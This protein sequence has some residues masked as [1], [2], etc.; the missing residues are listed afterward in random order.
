MLLE[1][2]GLALALAVAPPIDPQ[3]LE[4]HLD[5]EVPAR[6]RA[7]GVPGVVIS[8]VQGERVLLAKGWGLADVDA[9]T[10]MDGTRTVVRVASISKTVTATALAR[11]EARG[12]VDLDASIDRVLP[13]GLALAERFGEPVTVR[14]LLGHTAGIINNNVGRVARRPPAEALVDYLARTMPP[15]VRPPG[16]AV[17]YSNHGNALAGLAVEQLT[18]EPFA[19]HVEREILEPLGMHRSSFERRPDLEAAL[20][21]GYTV[22]DGEAA[23]YE[24]L[25]VRTVPAS[26]LH[27]TAADMARYMLMHLG[28]PGPGRA[29]LPP[30]AHQRMRTPGPGLHPALP[31]YH[32]AF[33]HGHTAGHPT[34]SHGGGLPG[35]LSRVVLF[36]EPQVGVFVAQNA[37]GT[38]IVSEL[39]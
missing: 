36:D 9:G 14:Q 6:L 1:S 17:L 29:V 11:L 16:V 26:M 27:T 22:E 35:F 3:R 32:Y 8:V 28:A 19:R 34:R 13:E 4:Q 12:R 21:T 5:Q 25:Y 15:H 38:S 37:D 7:S 18:A 24:D 31:S 2:A 30:P 10:P 20:A 23:V 39:V 33:A